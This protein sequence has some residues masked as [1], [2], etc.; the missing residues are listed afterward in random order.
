MAEETPKKCFV[1]A[2][3][4]EDNS[5]IREHSDTVLECLINPVL[6]P[7]G[8]AKAQR[9]DHLGEPGIITRQVVERIAKDDLVIA[10][11]SGHNPNVFYELAIRHASGLPF[12]QMIRKGEKIPFDVGQQ[13]TISFDAKNLRDAERVKT[14]LKKQ[15]EACFKD[16]FKMETPLGYAFDFQHLKS[17]DAVQRSLS[18]VLEK[19]DSLA[20]SQFAQT[21]NARMLAHARSARRALGV[22]AQ[23]PQGL[24]GSPAGFWGGGDTAHD[25]HP[26]DLGLKHPGQQ[27]EGS[28]TGSDLLLRMLLPNSD[29][30]KVREALV[31]LVQSYQQLALGV[32]SQI[33]EAMRKTA[34]GGSTDGEQLPVKPDDPP[35]T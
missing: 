25:V 3:I 18:L 33:A 32:G 35:K 15:V 8:F 13:R 28:L 17:G 2:P 34:E 5:E 26:F 24:Q 14:E 23:G 9:S 16:G 1:I 10:D 27:D 11:L 20:E 21:V 7:L 30:E 4:G 12:I 22:G 6:E 19:L 31:K 29:P